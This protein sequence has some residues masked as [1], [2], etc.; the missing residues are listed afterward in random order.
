MRDERSECRVAVV[1]EPKLLNPQICAAQVLRPL[2]GIGRLDQSLQH[3]KGD[4][5][6]AVAGRELVAFREFLD[7]RRQPGEELVVRLDRRAGA[8]RIVGH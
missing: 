6:N 8:L 4:A 1:Q 2:P 3:V 7:C 5:V